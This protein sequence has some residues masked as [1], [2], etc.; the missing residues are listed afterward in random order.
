MNTTPGHMRLLRHILLAAGALL[1]AGVSP[2][3]HAVAVTWVLQDVVFD[4]G[5]TAFGSFVYDADTNTFSAIDVTTTDGGALGGSHYQ[6]A[7]FE[8]GLL[9]ADSVL[10]VAAA[11]PGAGTP[12]FNMNLDQAMTNAGGTINLAMA[13]PPLAFESTCLTSLCDSFFNIDRVIVSGTITAVPLP[14]AAWLMG[15]ALGLLAGLGRRTGRHGG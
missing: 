6:F 15:C 13:P 3:A 12:A 14:A 10:L 1:A 5:G 2:T 4:D 9:D 11:N 8:A 7:N